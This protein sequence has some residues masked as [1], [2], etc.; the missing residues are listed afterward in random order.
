MKKFFWDIVYFKEITCG[1]IGKLILT[2][3]TDEDGELHPMDAYMVGTA[4]YTIDRV[5]Y[6][7]IKEES[8]VSM[9][10]HFNNLQQRNAMLDD[11]P[12]EIYRNNKD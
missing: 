4:Y 12:K 10:R 1:Y 5:S 2:G 11:L 8:K 6:D 3:I 9:Y 7:T